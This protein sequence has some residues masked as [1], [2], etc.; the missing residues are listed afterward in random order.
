M[1]LVVT[2]NN[3]CADPLSLVSID[4]PVFGLISQGKQF[5]TVNEAIAAIF[6]AQAAMKTH[7]AWLEQ[8]R[9][10]AMTIA[11]PEEAFALACM[12]ARLCAAIRD[13]GQRRAKE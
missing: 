6:D 4:P 11:T 5:A 1:Y 13:E 9:T 8:R 2:N 12:S 3:P 7:P 10:T